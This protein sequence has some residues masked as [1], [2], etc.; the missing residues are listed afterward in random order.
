MTACK[1]IK[2]W[3]KIKKKDSQL[4]SPYNLICQTFIKQ[5]N[6]Q[7]HK[8]KQLTN[9]TLLADWAT[10]NISQWLLHKLIKTLNQRSTE[11][12]GKQRWKRMIRT[13]R[14]IMHHSN[15]RAWSFHVRPIKRRTTLISR[16]A[17]SMPIEVLKKN[18]GINLQ[19]IQKQ[20]L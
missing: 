3:S 8:E 5:I 11:M 12:D 13:K 2:R 14:T 17:E 4:I 19:E 7:Q 15:P 10:F 20:A 6:N 9:Y 1:K 18:P 16:N